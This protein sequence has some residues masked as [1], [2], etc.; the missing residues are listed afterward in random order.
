MTLHLINL[1]RT[2]Q[3]DWCLEDC[4]EGEV[5]YW[6]PKTKKVY[7]QDVCWEKAEIG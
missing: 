1:M 3:C 2:Q 4:I 7:H 6:N 5:A